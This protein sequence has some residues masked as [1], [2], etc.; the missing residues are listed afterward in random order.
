MFT[1]VLVA[2]RGEIARR[3]IRTLRRMGIR[4]VAVYSDADAAEPHV[5]E[6]DV[7]VRLGPARP[8][9]SYLNIARIVDA[10]VRAGAEAIHPGYGFLSENAAFAQAVSDAG[11]VFIGP[12]VEALEVMGDK[13]RAK[14]RV[15][16]DGVPVIP[17]IAE[18]GLDDD[19]LTAAAAQIGYPV[20][21]KPSAGGGG[22]GMLDVSDPSELPEALRAARRVAAT[23]FGDDTLFLERLVTAPRHIEVQV[24]ADEHGR[25]IHLGERECSLQRRHQKVIEEAPSP[26]I[27]E[28]TRERIGAAACAVARSVDYRGAGTVE[29]LV[30]AEQP[31][32]F[33][34]MEMNTR[35]QVEHPVTELVTG[36]DI[37]EQQ[38]RIAAGEPLAVEQEQIR[39]S[40]HAV[41]A[42]VYAEDDQFLP[43]AGR[44]LELR[45]P[46]EVRVDS[47]IAGGSVIGGDYDPMLAKII[48]HAGT[49]EHAFAALARALERTVVLG[50]TTNTRFLHG[51]VTDPGV[52]SG[53]FDTTTIDRRIAERAPAEVPETT[54]RA[55]ALALHADAWRSAPTDSVWAAPTGWRLGGA[56]RGIDYRLSCD[57]EE[58]TLR[59][60][61]RPEAASVD[62]SPAACRAVDGALLVHI[63]GLTTTI[64]AARDDDVLWLHD[65]HGARA[66]RIIDR[67]AATAHARGAADDAA[68]ELRS[69]MP[70]TVVAV[71]ADD[72]THVAE[73]DT[74][75]VIEAMKMEHRITAPR[76][77]RV[78]LHVGHGQAVARDAVVATV[79]PDDQE[80]SDERGRAEPGDHPAPTPHEGDQSEHRT[81]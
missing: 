64:E 47:G 29:F 30:S 26:L 23:A 81:R 71:A 69:P 78:D 15:T 80:T 50:V 38:L 40:G 66:F 63:D 52:L 6:A 65:G 49:R 54:W 39:L 27:D 42:R 3:V 2:N 67:D 31:G 8:A 22:K 9:E 74:I 61:G 36:I 10:A 56:P 53:D 72:G 68:P 48:A 46:D 21:I 28:D 77:G 60:A 33:F 43:Q 57:G 75:L 20:L 35:L 62:S 12:G 55:A 76:A 70:G 5:R 7:A 37:V 13:I 34:F 14:Q 51:L 32:E 44:V 17:G 25:V 18:P 45:L 16:R 1:T 19:A 24:L 4:S 11:L 59:V 58:R 79:V 73:G 41:E